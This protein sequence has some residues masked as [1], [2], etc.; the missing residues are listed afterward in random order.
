MAD[1][2]LKQPENVEDFESIALMCRCVEPGCEV[3]IDFD[4]ERLGWNGEFDEKSQNVETYLRFLYRAD[5]FRR[6]FDWVSF[7]GKASGE[8]NK[9]AALL[10]KT[11]CSNNIPD[12]SPEYNKDR[13]GEHDI[14]YKLSHSEKG[15][16]YLAKRHCDVTGKPI[17][18][19]I[20]TINNQLPNG[21][22]TID[23]SG[24]LKKKPNFT[25]GR[26]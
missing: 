15:K 17:D 1:N 14:K 23:A 9:F 25:N 18:I 11:Q 16:Q 6:A 7:S 13:G 10:K 8:I 21:L 22:F 3:E 5:I 20:E 19:D 12:G 26:L 4:F 24:E 2:G